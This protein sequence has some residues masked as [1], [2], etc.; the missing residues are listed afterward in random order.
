VLGFVLAL[1]PSPYS[2]LLISSRHQEEYNHDFNAEISLPPPP[3]PPPVNNVD[4]VTTTIEVQTTSTNVEQAVEVIGQEQTLVM[5]DDSMS[6]TENGAD[7]LNEIQMQMQVQAQ[8]ELFDMDLERMH[9]NLYRDKY[10]TPD[11]FLSDIRKIVHNANVRVEEDPE[12]LFRA[13]AMLTAAEVSCQDFDATFRMECERMAVRETKRQDEYRKNKSQSRAA[14]AEARQESQAQPPRRSTRNTGQPLEISY[15]DPSKLERKLKRPRSTEGT[16]EPSEAESNDAHAAKRSRVSSAEIQIDDT[17]PSTKLL[18][19]PPGRSHAVRFVEN[20]ADRP[21]PVSPTP[22][23]NDL[24]PTFPTRNQ[25]AS[26]HVGGF[27][28]F[29]LNPM[30]P[31][32]SSATEQLSFT[33][34]QYHPE[35]V[36]D[37]V[38]QPPVEHSIPQ[39]VSQPIDQ[40]AQAAPQADT[41]MGLQPDPSPSSPMLHDQT[42]P[43]EQPQAAEPVAESINEQMIIVEQTPP[44]LPDFHVDMDAVSRLKQEL[45]CV[46]EPLNVEEL[47]QLRAMC[48]ARVW[49]HRSAWDR[50]LLAEELRILLREFVEEVAG[51]ENDA[52][53]P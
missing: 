14:K 27:D 49:K 36:P 37:Y 1:V 10:L 9:I 24:V 21:E 26:A 41:V 42:Q 28:P 31:P 39:P 29:L 3:S 47:E 17:Q 44:P 46:T 48:L 2:Q 15:A 4:S 5:A 12:R 32:V 23:A 43:V 19:T 18:D 40:N 50:S 13:Q 8:P 20:I 16:A 53:T 34:S 25:E 35:Q 11:G 6:V 7:G 38:T 22:H 52:Y 30:T 33:S 51:D 45:Q